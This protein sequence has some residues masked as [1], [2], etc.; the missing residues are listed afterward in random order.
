MEKKICEITGEKNPV[1]SGGPVHITS[2][3]ENPMGQEKVQI[4]FVIENVKSV[5]GVIF[6]KDA[7]SC[8]DSINNPDLHKVWVNVKTEINGAG[9]ECNGLNEGSGSS[10]GYVTLYNGE[11]RT[12]TCSIDLSHIDSIFEQVY[13]IE[14]EYRYLQHIER[15]LEIRDV[16]TS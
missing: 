9:A 7:Q 13:E 1:N 15:P 10:Q 11:P 6:S 8:D 5:P 3:K 2:L 14:L 4:T 16:S 12:V